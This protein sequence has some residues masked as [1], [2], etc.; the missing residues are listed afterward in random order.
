MTSR[1][2]IRDLEI[3][4]EWLDHYEAAPDDDSGSSTKLVAE[5][6][7]EEIRRREDDMAIRTIMREYG[8]T[9]SLASKLLKAKK[10]G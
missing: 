7:R 3:A 9:R 1:V 8:L 2:G 10:N 5:W 4:A 6:I